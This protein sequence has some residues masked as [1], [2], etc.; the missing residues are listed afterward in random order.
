MDKK[1]PDCRTPIVSLMFLDE[2]KG[3]E[4]YCERCGH[5]VLE[6]KKPAPARREPALV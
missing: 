3:P 1:C 5:A 6:A 4:F 2:K